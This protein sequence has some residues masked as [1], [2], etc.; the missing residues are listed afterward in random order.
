MY[1]EMLL[2]SNL[3]KVAA[4]LVHY[5]ESAVS[6]TVTVSEVWGSKFFEWAADIRCGY[7]C[8]VESSITILER[9]RVYFLSD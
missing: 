4:K 7:N 2:L 3:D 1:Q 5:L 6:V 8:E 9:Q